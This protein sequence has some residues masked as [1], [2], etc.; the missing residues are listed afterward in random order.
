MLAEPIAVSMM[1]ANAL[2]SLGV[3]YA[4]R[5]PLASAVHGVLHATMDAD[6][7]AD[8]RID[9]VEALVRRLGRAFYIDEAV[10]RDAIH[11][12][13]SFNL[14]H[15]ETMVEV[16]VFVAK[17]RPFDR[18]PLS[19]R[20]HHALTE[21]ADA[22]ACITTAED[23]VLSKL[24]WYQMSGCVS[25]RQWRGVLGVLKVQGDRLDLNDLR[26]MAASL[27]VADLLRRAL[28]ETAE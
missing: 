27:D 21:E 12:R 16:D 6:F 2:E 10:V 5:S 11:R 9:H 18:A 3:P 7:V 28:H 26:R 23:V 22:L 14:I 15:F 24:E 4:L 25:E 8:L 20:Q 17:S 1:V 19:R 13:T